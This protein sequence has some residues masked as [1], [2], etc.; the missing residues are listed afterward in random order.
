MN[1]ACAKWHKRWLV[2]KD[3]FLCHLHPKTGKI[4]GVMLMDSEFEVSRGILAGI[5]HGIIIQNLSR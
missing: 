5:Q 4:K 1:N 3:T 2:V